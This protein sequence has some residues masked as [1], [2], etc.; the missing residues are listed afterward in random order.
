MLLDTAFLIDVMRGREAA[1]KK[2]KEM[3]KE[4]ISQSVGAPTIYELYVGVALSDKP[5]KEKERVLGV[6]L[7]ASIL[8]LDAKGAEKAGRLQGELIKEGDMLDPEDVMIAGIAIVNGE[9]IITRNTEHFGRI[10]E[11]KIETY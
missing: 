2:L 9:R 1:V 7:S 8:G 3:E 6:L 11:L 4:R 10:K 5:E